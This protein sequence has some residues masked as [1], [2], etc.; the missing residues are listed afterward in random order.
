MKRILLFIAICLLVIPV[1]AQPTATFSMSAINSTDGNLWPVTGVVKGQ[2]VYFNYTGTGANYWTWSYGDGFGDSGQNVTHAYT[3][4]RNGYSL[5]LV[6]GVT[7]VTISLNATD[8]AGDVVIGSQFLNLS[9][10][11]APIIY[12]GPTDTI[13]PLNE[14][15]AHAFIAVI[16][17]NSS[18][19]AG[20]LGIDFLGGLGVASDVYVSVV[21]ATIFFMIVFAIPFVMQ[22]I[23]SKDFVVAGIM[24]GLIGVWMINRLPGNMK[25]LAVTFIAMSI[26]AIIYSLLKERM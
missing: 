14:T 15:Y 8:N 4:G 11:M 23:I 20:W 9:S 24:G 10:A 12:V 26:V 18:V 2:E 5:L 1:V 7:T 3:F 17:G 25:L 13:E 19:P 6:N 16:G 21:G 22:W